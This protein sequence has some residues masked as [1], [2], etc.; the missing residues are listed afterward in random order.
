MLHSF[1]RT[2]FATKSYRLL[3]FLLLLLYA[4][5]IYTE[6]HPQLKDSLL[7]LKK[8]KKIGA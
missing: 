5:G 1:G 4:Q 8:Q 3:E 6:A 2:I 7:F